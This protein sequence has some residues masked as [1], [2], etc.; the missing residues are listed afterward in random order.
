MDG[1][2]NICSRANMS[3]DH[4]KHMTLDSVAHGEDLQECKLTP[5]VS[6]IRL[7]PHLASQEITLEG[8]KTKSGF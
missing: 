4:K 6:D 5:G 1:V 7:K 8:N 3:S 2:G